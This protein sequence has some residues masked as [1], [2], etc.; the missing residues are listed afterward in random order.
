M[1]PPQQATSSTKTPACDEQTQKEK[2]LSTLRASIAS[3]QSQITEIESQ[4]AQTKAKLKNDPSTTV[5]RHIRLLHEYNE[6]KDIAQGLMGLIADARGVRQVD[7]QREYEVD[8][9]D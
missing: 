7:V 1:P 9:G 2:K 5:K 4:I 6:I 3:L 8:D